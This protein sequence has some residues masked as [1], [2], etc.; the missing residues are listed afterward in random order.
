MSSPI[1]SGSVGK[2]SSSCA[3]THNETKEVKKTVTPSGKTVETPVH[4]T[5]KSVPKNTDSTTKSPCTQ[6][7]VKKISRD[8][9]KALASALEEYG[10]KTQEIEG[11]QREED[12][13]GRL[14]Q[15]QT[16]SINARESRVSKLEERI[17]KRKKVGEQIKADLESTQ[18]KL[19]T[20][21]AL[22]EIRDS[23]KPAFGVS[24][25]RLISKLFE[26]E[27]SKA[28]NKAE[29]II[30]IVDKYV[31]EDTLSINIQTKQVKLLNSDA[32]IRCIDDKAKDLDVACDLSSLAAISEGQLPKLARYL[33]ESVSSGK[34]K[35]AVIKVT[36]PVSDADIKSLA[37]LKL[38]KLELYLNEESA[39]KL[40][41]MTN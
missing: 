36:L 32:L 22:Q 2:N 26:S 23:L 16:Q 30:S 6:K 4:R 34:I 21:R 17:A 39:A 33:E 25:V 28:S 38:Q 11:L 10:Q 27:I 40:K 9:K 5:S 41:A 19:K 31:D 14:I 13:L 1:P 35:S 37:S 29:F 12:R 8:D 20:A 24:F 15:Q 7:A 18:E 3:L